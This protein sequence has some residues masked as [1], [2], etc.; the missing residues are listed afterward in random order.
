M[1]PPNRVQCFLTFFHCTWPL[2]MMLGIGATLLPQT[3]TYLEYLEHSLA[4]L[5]APFF[6]VFNRTESLYIHVFIRRRP[7]PRPKAS[8]ISFSAIY[9]NVDGR[10]N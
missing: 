1:R 8:Q 9:S 7:E 3:T 5:R 2:Y 4:N 10:T 6:F